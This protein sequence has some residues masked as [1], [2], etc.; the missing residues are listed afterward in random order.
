MAGIRC[1]VGVC[2]SET[3]C[4]SAEHLQQC[5]MMLQEEAAATIST[6]GHTQRYVRICGKCHVD[7]WTRNGEVRLVMVF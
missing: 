5:N 7:L 3:L 6:S 1:A 4:L 2:N